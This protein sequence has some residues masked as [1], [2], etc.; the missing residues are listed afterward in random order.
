MSDAETAKKTADTAAQNDDPSRMSLIDHLDELR[1]RIIYALITVTIGSIASWFVTLPVLNHLIKGAGKVITLG[2]ADAFMWRIKL[3][4]ILGVIFCAPALLYQIWLFIK[5]AL[6]PQERRFVFP[7]VFSGTILF[8]AGAFFGSLVIPMTLQFLEGF[9][10]GSIE[11]TYTL[12]KYLSFV[13]TFVIAFGV[14]FELPVVLIL[15]AKMG[16]VS[17][18]FLVANR[19]F[20]VL[21]SLIVGSIMTPADVA[22]MFFL[23][24]PLMLLYEISVIIIKFMKNPVRK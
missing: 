20:A 4:I 11:P 1:S 23:A 24:V 19:K 3:A 8:F 17:H 18:Q 15:L 21:I 13:G 5:P 22:S 14:V 16:L 6:L 10:G 2:P 12:D 9:A 7:V